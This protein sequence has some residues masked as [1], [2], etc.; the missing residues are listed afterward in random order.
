MTPLTQLSLINPEDVAKMLGLSV[1][2]I[3]QFAQRG[4]LPS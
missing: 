1:V 2:Y 4:K 3:Y